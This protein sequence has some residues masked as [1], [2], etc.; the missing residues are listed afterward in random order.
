MTNLIFKRY[1]LKNIKL[2]NYKRDYRLMNHFPNYLKRC[3][4]WF[5]II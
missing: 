1:I 3:I 2:E 5:I 4:N